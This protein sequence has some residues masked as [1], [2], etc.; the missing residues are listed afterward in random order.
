MRNLSKFLTNQKG[1]SM[2][3]VVGFLALAVPVVTAALALAGTLSLDSLVKGRLARTQFSYQGI[4]P[5]F[6]NPPGDEPPEYWCDKTIPLNKQQITLTCED[7]PGPPGDAPPLVNR[8][9]RSYKEV[10]RSAV[11]LAQLATDPTFTYI[12]RTFNDAGADGETHHGHLGH[13]YWKQPHHFGSWVGYSPSQS[14]D[15]VFGIGNKNP[16]KTLLSAMQEGGGHQEALNRHAVAAL[17]NAAHPDI[18]SEYSV[19]S[20]ISLVQA[21]YTTSDFHSYERLVREEDHDAHFLNDDDD[22]GDDDDTGRQ[23]LQRI[24]DGLPPGFSYVDNSSYI[25]NADAV[26]PAWEQI[27]DPAIVTKNDKHYD[28]DDDDEEECD[29]DDEEC[30]DGNLGPNYWK[31]ANNFASWTGY[32]QNAFF[33]TVF[34]AGPLDKTLIQI[35]NQNSGTDERK[36]QKEAV[37]ALLNAAHPGIDFDYSETEVKT[38][39]QQA[40]AIGEPD[41]DDVEEDLKEANQDAYYKDAGR[42]LLIWDLED[43]DVYVLSGEMLELKFDAE[44]DVPAGNYCNEAWMEPGYKDH[45]NGD[46]DD[47]GDDEDDEGNPWGRGTGTDMTAGVKVG[48]PVD[49]VCPGE[50]V[51]ITTTVNPP[52]TVSNVPQEFTYK[53][54]LKNVGTTTLHIARINDILPPGFTYVGPTTG[55]TTQPPLISELSGSKHLEWS[56]AFADPLAL[57]LLSGEIVTLSFKASATPTLDNYTNEVWVYFTEFSGQEEAAYTWPTAVIRAMDVFVVTARDAEGNVIGTYQV[58]VGTDETI[59]Q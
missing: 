15:G 27:D 58:W 32:A 10:D 40:Y 8:Q 9:L 6:E 4:P 49:Q 21:A 18:D 16:G 23:R 22:D 34:G 43:L 29:D 5:L 56:G 31:Q 12:I 26:P 37:A 3:M 28:D 1:V 38:K 11:T 54:E 55:I 7:Q 48:S 44:A 41:F 51:Y 52:I 25:W 17:L 24:Y 20:V 19:N 46:D 14:F 50:A 30:D 35:L 36:M 53:I 59:V 2:I 42:T 47:D 57:E 45:D 13:G 39:V 33:G